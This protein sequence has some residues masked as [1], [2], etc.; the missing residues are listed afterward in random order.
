MH[1]CG[2]QWNLWL[3]VFEGVRFRWE[4][5]AELESER[6]NPGSRPMAGRYGVVPVEDF[7]V[8]MRVMENLY[9]G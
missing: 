4:I 5:M 7:R 3:A 6:C 9:H 2:R 8:S 1:G